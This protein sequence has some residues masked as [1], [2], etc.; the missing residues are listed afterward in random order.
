[1]L[2]ITIA[3]SG[4]TGGDDNGNG[5]G[6]ANTR[7]RLAV[8]YAERQEVRTASLPDGGF[9]VQLRFPFVAQVSK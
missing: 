5:V 2:E 8:L 9:S 6:L 1:M 3:N 7:E 4:S